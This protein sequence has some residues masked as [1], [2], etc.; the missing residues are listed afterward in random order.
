MP[1]E[2]WE[3]KPAWT[4][5]PSTNGWV[6]RAPQQESEDQTQANDPWRQGADPWA[7]KKKLDD[8]WA[9]RSEQQHAVAPTSAASAPTGNWGEAQPAN[10]SWVSHTAEAPP[11]NSNWGSSPPAQ[12]PG[13]GMET[14]DAQKQARQKD[15]KSYQ[16]WYIQQGMLPGKSDEQVAKDEETFFKVNPF[17]GAGADFSLYDAVSCE[18]SGP[19]TEG[20]PHIQTFEQLYSTC[21]DKIPD[22]LEKNI[23]SCGYTRPTP[24]QKYAIPCAVMGRDVMCC[25]QT[26]SGKTAAFL[27]PMLASMIKNHRAT[28]SLTQPFSGPCKPDTLVLTP[29]RELCLQIYAEAQKFCHRT[30]FRCCRIYGKEPPRIQLEQLAFGADVVVATPGRLWDFVSSAVIEVTSVNCLVLDEADRMIDQGMELWLKDIAE[31]YGM[32]PKEERQTMMFSATF[33]AQ[34]Q[35][36]AKDYLYEHVWVGVGKVG[37]AT[38][39]IQQRLLQVEASKKYDMLFDMLMRFLEDRAQGERIMVFTNSKLQAKGLDEKLWD[40][41][42]DTGALHGDLTQDERESNLQKFRDGKIDVLVCTDVASRGLDIGGVSHIINFDLPREIEVYVQRIGR[43][44]RIG[45]RGEAISFVVVDA[46]GTLQEEE[47]M[48]R[49]LVPTMRD[50]NSEVPEWLQKHCDGIDTSWAPNE[51]WWERSGAQADARARKWEDWSTA[52][53]SVPATEPASDGGGWSSAAAVQQAGA[54][55]SNWSDSA[56]SHGYAPAPHLEANAGSWFVSTPPPQAYAAG[57][58]ADNGNWVAATQAAPAESEHAESNG[59]ALGNSSWEGAGAGS[60][61]WTAASGHVTDIGGWVEPM[62]AEQAAAD[63]DTAGRSSW[64][65]AGAGDSWSVAGAWESPEVP[66]ADAGAVSQGWGEASSPH[67]T[68]WP[69]EDALGGDAGAGPEQQ[70]WT[71]DWAA[72]QAA[73]TSA[74]PVTEASWD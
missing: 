6:E 58:V 56:P 57:Q 2:W 7:Q 44:G 40:S 41:K 33:P 21:R 29:T 28:G 50:A 36:M 73:E 1:G 62:Q 39:T 61:P 68:A 45:H 17:Q 15:F 49:D 35:E 67:A 32:P 24:V 38:S 20:M 10:S 8:P 16:D 60:N 11:A 23:R 43:T 51:N 55:A 42:I 26:G 31:N 22:Q 30:P 27:V 9:Q 19:K 37:G 5:A 53:A 71:D 72:A 3:S 14:S 4:E 18:I 34:I 47:R 54:D 48:L 46:Q 70:G 13:G 64:E 65:A 63:G 59:S 25:A 74:P 52:A 69:P 12:A 66:A